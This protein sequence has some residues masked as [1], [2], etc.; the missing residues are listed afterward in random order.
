VQLLLWCARSHPDSETSAKI[1]LHES[2][3]DWTQL[4]GLAV[5]HGVVP[6]LYRTLRNADRSAV[7]VH[8]LDD[9]RQRAHGHAWKNVRLARQLIDVLRLLEADGIRA[10]SFKGPTLAASAYG[11]LA[12]REIADLDVLIH[13]R[14]LERARCLLMRA[15]YAYQPSLPGRHLWAEQQLFYNQAFVGDDSIVELHWNVAERYFGCR[16]DVEALR[17]RA[18]HG[19]LLGRPVRQ[20]APEDLLQI[21]CI[22]G[23]RHCWDRLLLICDVAY[24]VRSHPGM[25]WEQVM[26]GA[27][28]L[29]ALRM[30]LLALELARKMCGTRL[31]DRVADPIQADRRVEALARSVCD[32]ILSGS[33]APR[34]DS[35]RRLFH[36]RM[37][38][39]LSDRIRYCRYTADIPAG[40]DRELLPLRARLCIRLAT[41]LTPNERDWQ[42]LPLPPSLSFF[43]VL[44][45]PIR[46]AWQAALMRVSPVG[47]PAEGIGPLAEAAGGVAKVPGANRSRQPDEAPAMEARSSR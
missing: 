42:F 8:V 19:T 9:L 17:T 38:E 35:E 22:H 12:L 47:I 41:L 37:Y 30:T 44:L 34:R 24:L 5:E 27:E 29:G 2:E 6:L 43:Y 10:I 21:L 18:L 16:L 15:G 7:P 45:R 26:T 13:R 3:V 32:S 20:V 4:V 39:R 40:A 1:A 11:D 46:L 14:E 23:T 28:S 36:V 25:K 31:P 33:A